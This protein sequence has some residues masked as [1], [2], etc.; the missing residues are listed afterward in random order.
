[1]DGAWNRKQLT[2]QFGGPPSLVINEPLRRAGASTTKVPKGSNPLMIRLRCGKAFSRR[3]GVPL[4]EIR[5]IK[6]P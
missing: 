1:M 3:G 6:A 4:A 5:W 2:P